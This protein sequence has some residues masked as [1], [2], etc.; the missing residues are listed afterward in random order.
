[1]SRFNEL[2]AVGAI[3]A[4]ERKASYGGALMPEEVYELMQLSDRVKLIDVRTNAEREFVGQIPGT[5]GVQYLSYS[6][7]AANVAFVPMLKEEHELNEGDYLLFIC[8]S[9]GRSSMTATLATQAGFKN[10]FNVIDGFEGDKSEQKRRNCVNRWRI[11]GLPW[12][13]S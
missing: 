3:R 1:M 2:L 5:I 9:G 11:A 12:I 8:R 7:W 13:Q 6:E 10:C 4:A